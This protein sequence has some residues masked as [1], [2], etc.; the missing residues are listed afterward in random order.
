LARVGEI[1]IRRDALAD[2]TDVPPVLLGT[3]PGTPALTPMS[4]TLASMNAAGLGRAATLRVSPAA[5]LRAASRPARLSSGR[6]A[7]GG[8][9]SRV[10]P[11]TRAA[12]DATVA[13]AVAQQNLVF[14]AL[15]AAECVYQ[16]GN[17]PAD[18]KGRPEL[19]KIAL[20]CGLF[21]GAFALIQT[22]Q[23]VLSPGGLALG[24]VA[25]FFSGKYFLDRYD[26][27][28]PDGM[29]WPGPR[30]FPGTGIIF[31]LFVFLANVEALPRI[32]NDF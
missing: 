31:S 9:R 5:R 32:L 19:P 13:Y 12:V 21:A 20:P 18:Y 3:T 16:Q 11:V 26:A 24:A 14:A 22:D 10:A 6:V 2:R 28:V 1:F 15:V 8:S 30:V 27:I 7:P 17:L 23:T 4:V 29:D 25:C